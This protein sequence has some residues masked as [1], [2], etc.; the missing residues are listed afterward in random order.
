MSQRRRRGSGYAP[1]GNMHAPP[2]VMSKPVV[3]IADVPAE[4]PPPQRK[5]RR[6]SGQQQH[7]NVPALSRSLPYLKEVLR[8]VH[9]I[10]AAGQ[11]TK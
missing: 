6:R 1:R 8:F 10:E 11:E 7:R 4:P 2:S 9:L 5:K 3:S